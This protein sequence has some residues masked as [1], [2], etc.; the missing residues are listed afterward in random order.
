MEQNI[1]LNNDISLSEGIHNLNPLYGMSRED[2]LS[3]LSS[4]DII[5]NKQIPMRIKQLWNW[6]YVNGVDDINSMQNISKPIRD[7]LQDIY[8]LHR[9]KIVTEQKSSDGT[10]KWLIALEDKLGNS[11][12]NEIETVYIPDGKRG[13]LCLSSQIGC[14]L[15]CSFCFTG[16]Q[17][18]VRTLSTF[19][20]LLACLI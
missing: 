16:T 2:L 10:I 5:P 7:K 11:S 1:N 6:T 14:T 12:G 17:K 9:P 4:L 8:T 19:E 13:T 3:N 20:I 18:L 15:N